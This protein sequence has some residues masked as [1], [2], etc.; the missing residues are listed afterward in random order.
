M[1]DRFWFSDA[2]WAAIERH[3]PKNQRGARRV[4]DRRVISSILQLQSRIHVADYLCAD[5]DKPV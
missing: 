3:L 2:A 1:S 5:G 4:D